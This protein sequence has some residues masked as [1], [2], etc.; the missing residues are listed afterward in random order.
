MLDV[1]CSVG[2]PLG[3]IPEERVER[4]QKLSCFP[5]SSNSSISISQAVLVH[6]SA[7]AG[8]AGVAAEVDHPPS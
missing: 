4:A 7:S 8:R 1:A 3:V 5:C 6:K 2:F